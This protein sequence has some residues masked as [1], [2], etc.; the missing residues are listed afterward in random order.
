MEISQKVLGGATFLTHTVHVAV[1]LDIGFDKCNDN[2]SCMK[3]T[4]A[5]LMPGIYSVLLMLLLTFSH[6]CHPASSAQSTAMS[7]AAGLASRE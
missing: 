2:K 1:L 3:Q 7:S 6:F 5:V 4:M